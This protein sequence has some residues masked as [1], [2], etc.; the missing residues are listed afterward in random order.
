MSTLPGIGSAVSGDRSAELTTAQ[1]WAVFSPLH[2]LW[3]GTPAVHVFFVLSG[4]VLV[5]PF[6]KPGAPKSWAQYYAK[7]F[8]RLYLPAWASLAVAVALILMIPRTASPLQSPWADMYVIDPSLGQVFKDSLLMLNASTINTPL[9][10]L[11]WEV[12]FSLLLPAYVFIALRWRRFW[13]VKIG[14]AL[15]LA[16]V[17]ALQDVEWLSYL[18]IFAIGA[19]LGAERERIS[20]LTRSWPRAVWFFVAA[21]GIFLANAEWVSPG[22]PVP[23]VEAVVTVGAVLIVLLFVSC[24]PAKRLG[25]TA[26]AQWLGRVSFSLYLVHLPIILAAVTLLR[27]VSLPLA[28]AISV[29]ASLVVAELFFRYVEQ[30]AHRLSTAVGRAVGRRTRRDERV[31]A[32]DLPADPHVPAATPVRELADATAGPR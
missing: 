20:A 17:G 2:V 23:G 27:S 8:F 28:L 3:N 29:A 21:A 31:E 26:V 14:L 22:Q 12:L 32:A 6:T 30:P 15:L 4:F 1:W 7:R 9:W 11:K 16:A 24:G 10:S 19:V 18:P 13:H 25:D 5:L